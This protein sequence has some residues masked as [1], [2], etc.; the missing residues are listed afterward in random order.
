MTT[1]DGTV[2]FIW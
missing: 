2:Y 1:R